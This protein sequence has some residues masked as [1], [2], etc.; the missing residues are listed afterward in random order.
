VVDYVHREEVAEHGEEIKPVLR[1]GAELLLARISGSG[2]EEVGEN[3]VP[4]EQ[5]AV[6]TEADEEGR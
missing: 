1:E 3:V 2:A 6:A 4:G 5:S